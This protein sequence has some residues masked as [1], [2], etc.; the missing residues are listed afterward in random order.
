VLS[1]GGRWDG[2][3]FV[4]NPGNSGAPD[5]SIGG[6]A[7]FRG[8]RMARTVAE[9]ARWIFGTLAN[10]SAGALPESGR[11]EPCFTAPLA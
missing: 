10:H 7:V 1:A 6:T 2:K 9:L 4:G 5:R 11:T 3:L 8:G